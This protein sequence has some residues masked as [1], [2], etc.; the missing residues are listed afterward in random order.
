[1]PSPSVRGILIAT[2][3]IAAFAIVAMVGESSWLVWRRLG[4]TQR[5]ADVA[6]AT[7]SVF[8]AMPA[9]RLDRSNT[10]RVLS[11]D[12]AQ[13][14]VDAQVQESR[15][16]F[17]PAAQAATVV[18]ARLDYP[19]GA[20]LKADLAAEL[21]TVQALMDESLAAMRKPKAERRATLAA[22][23]SR[24]TTKLIDILDAN[25]SA[26]GR[27]V[28]LQDGMVDALL[29]VKT[30]LWA[31]RNAAGDGTLLVSNAVGGLPTPP[32]AVAQ[33]NAHVGRAQTAWTL[34]RAMTDGMIVDGRLAAAFDAGEKSFFARE[35]LDMQRG[36]LAKVVGG[37]KP[38]MGVAEWN[39]GN[40][41]RLAS[42]LAPAT[43]AL[44]LA[45]NRAE[46]ESA[47]A[48]RG[49][50]TSLGI[51]VATIVIAIG[52]IIGINRRI[53]GPLV[54][55]RDRMLKLADGDLTVEA[56][57]T[58]R[59]DEIGAL[60]HAMAVFRGNMI[61]GEKLRAE[62]AEEE[63]RSAKRRKAESR[64]IADGF[65]RA[66]GGIVDMVAAA[67]SRLQDSAG[68]LTASADE[69]AV[70]ST[71]VAAASEQASA[72]VASVASA[73]EELSSS[74][75]EIA[76]QVAQSAAIAAKAVREAGET[77]E[78]VRGLAQAADKIGS[79]VGLIN[80]IAGQ[81]NLLALNATIEAARAGDAGKGFAVV[82]AE[83]KQLADQ[84]AKATAD[85]STQIGAIQGAT[86]QA[87]HAIAAIGETI[88]T[89]NTITSTIATA[90]DGQGAATGEIARNIQEASRGTA[91]VSGSIAGVNQAA[92]QSTSAAAEV[93]A[94]ASELSRQADTLRGEVAK[95]L[96]TVRAA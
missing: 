38:E 11:Y 52:C 60:G 68:T 71:A 5:I 13:A 90:V 54:V 59:G 80:Q 10:N 35:A 72:N 91:E 87:A 74:V 22:D 34:A 40:V 33:F 26:I 93:L 63:E 78:Q 32:D 48:L 56:P 73:T 19:D 50:M 17:L 27:L 92:A 41:P 12:A 66:V 45:N 61:Q 69:T 62:R 4:E 84:T 65:D 82:A 57:Y 16:T 89:M 21:K 37:A 15:A 1:M 67:A 30:N 9:V 53:V 95:F 25:S 14:T 46:V 3:G 76:R 81:T 58:H 42:V 8:T 23:Y 44:D 18:L 43:V 94:S 36:V 49:L 70:K 79:I 47:A 88:E 83:V 24:E 31:A 51:L 29:A 2:I 86:E 96:E 39:S 55:I 75:T 85:I 7:R 28:K 6:A 77:N 64:A 20:R